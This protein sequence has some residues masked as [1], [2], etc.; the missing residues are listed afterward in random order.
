MG[1]TLRPERAG[2]SLSQG[3]M[4]MGAHSQTPSRVRSLK[5]ADLDSEQHLCARQLLAKRT[6]WT[7]ARAYL[8]V[9]VLRTA[10]LSS[11]AHPEGA[12]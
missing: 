12:M 7:T 1:A 11:Q 3:V 10:R 5:P 6:N 2:I 9:G 8:P 4:P